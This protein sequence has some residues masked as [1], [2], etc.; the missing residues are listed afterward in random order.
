[1]LI[2]TEHEYSIN[3][4][5]FN[6][7]AINDII[8]KEISGKVQN[9][10]SIEKITISKELQKHV[11]EFKPTH[12]SE[13]L[14]SLEKEL[15]S[16]FLRF[17]ALLDHKYRFLGT[18]M[19][20]LLKL[21][22]TSY[23]EHG[24]EGDIYREYDRLF[25]IKQHGFL[26]IQALQVNIQYKNPED[27]ILLYNKIRSLLPFLIAITAA[28]PFVDG[29]TTGFMDNRLIYYKENQK[30]IP[31]ICNNVISEKLRTKEDY[32]N[33]LKRIYAELEKENANIL[34]R[35]WIPSMGVI[36]RFSRNCLEIKALDEQECI[37]SDMAVTAFLLSLLKSKELS[38]DDEENILLE[39][40]EKAIRYGTQKLKPELE[41]LY[42]IAW[43]NSNK[44]EMGYLP[45][46]KR[47]IEEGSIAEMFVHQARKE[48]ISEI[49]KAFEKSLENNKPYETPEVI[50]ETCK[51]K[52]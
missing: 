36:I 2:G 47:R 38:L 43:K 33:I 42:K 21:D 13:S 11:L 46:I 4:E 9:E 39:L 25:N 5:K 40:S 44:E 18:G 35:E 19:H 45:L 24:E 51:V 32:M 15:H 52:K 16:G 10:F 14:I 8:I 7:L 37:H 1:M 29:K 20:P 34:C 23:W 22:E 48:D 49:L 50:N 12:P 3:D 26:N 28:S 27:M 41:E 17:L 6:P 31:I 30:R